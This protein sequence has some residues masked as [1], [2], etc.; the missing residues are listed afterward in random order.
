MSAVYHVDENGTSTQLVEVLAKNEDHDLQRVLDA[1]LDLLPGDQ[2]RPEDPCRWLN[3]YREMKVPDPNSGSNRWEIDHLLADH[4]A[5]P[6]FVEAKRYKDT[7]ARR[8]V[9]GQMM[10]YAANGQHY[11][12]ADLLK[13]LADETAKKQNTTLEERIMYLTSGE[14]EVDEYFELLETN[15]KDSHFRLVFFLEQ[16]S[17]ELRSIV[18]FLN[19]QMDR[20]EVLLVE[21]KMYEHEGDRF[22]V[23]RLFG[24]TEAARLKK[25]AQQR[26]GT[27]ASAVA[28]N[29]ETFYSSLRQNVDEA[30]FQ[31]I[32]NIHERALG[33]GLNVSFGTASLQLRL[34][35][36]KNTFIGFKTNGTLYLPML[37]RDSKCPPEKAEFLK[38]HFYDPLVEL[39]GIEIGDKTTYKENVSQWLECPQEVLDLI[40]EVFFGDFS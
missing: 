15:L 21:A 20:T 16:S 17:Y 25:V 33:N 5:I 32:Q 23:P 31:R 37:H 10:E 27:G 22:V 11:W 38:Q 39:T 36:M 28:L 13:G 35:F 30:T 7:R 34:S 1:N 14:M 12:D 2:I 4:T 6:T 18:E 3:I 40:E 24:Y 9:I 19:R 8:E 26:S 29:Y